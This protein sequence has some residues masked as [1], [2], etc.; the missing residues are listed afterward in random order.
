MKAAI[1]N[2]TGLQKEFEV[3]ITYPNGE[4]EL[5]SVK[6][7]FRYKYNLATD[8]PEFI[9]EGIQGAKWNE[10]T[11]VYF[12]YTFSQEECEAIEVQMEDQI[13]W[14][15]IIDYLNNWNNRD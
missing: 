7:E 14:E 10:V 5:Y 15:D 8:T 2:F 9:L 11:N 3:D 4:T 1:D 6:V 12:P 13:D